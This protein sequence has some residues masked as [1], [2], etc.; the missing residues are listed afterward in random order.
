MYGYIRLL[1]TENDA[2]DYDYYRSIY[3]SLCHSLEYNFGQI[4]RFLLSYDVTFMALIADALC[5]YQDS[6]SKMQAIKQ[7]CWHGLGKTTAVFA[8]RAYL[9]YAANVSLLLAEQ[10]LIDDK[11][12]KEH[13][14]KRIISQFLFK[15]A[16]SQ[17]QKNY[18]EV[19]ESIA[20]AMQNFNNLEAKFKANIE[21]DC[22]S[23]LP[24]ANSFIQTNCHI[25]I[26]NCLQDLSKFVPASLE[27]SCAF[28]EVLAHVFKNIPLCVD[29]VERPQSTPIK[30]RQFATQDDW[31]CKLSDCLAV[32]GAYLGSWL[33]LIDA[34][35]DLAADIMNDKFNILLTTMSKD[36]QAV[37]KS[38]L[39][40][41][42]SNLSDR[43]AGLVA[44]NKWQAQTFTWRPIESLA[45][46][47]R[48]IFNLLQ[49]SSQ[50]IQKI[51]NTLD[52]S[53]ALLPYQRSASL[54]S[55]IIQLGLH[56]SLE[57]NKLRQAYL[58]NLLQ[59]D[60]N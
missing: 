42:H 17:A 60:K 23:L 31:G 13:F 20:N 44:R 58:F 29:V 54:L 33:Y 16:F 6:D 26:E 18:P 2:K 25:Q 21:N 53:M 12:D 36:L 32:I 7:N 46:H 28:A 1:K 27:T 24:A 56:S 51:Q 35:S 4:P 43:L 55:K 22:K 41:K 38:N 39:L 59:V 30:I 3:C 15:S 5:P 11:L 34:L 48:T 8:N 40:Q 57:H 49:T 9:D 37:I 10:K 19:S 47:E 52:C 45:S 50:A 14:S